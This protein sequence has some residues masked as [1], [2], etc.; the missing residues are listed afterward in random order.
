M[1]SDPQKTVFISYRRS[2]SRYLARLIFKSLHDA[3]YDV[4]L[5]VNTIDSGAFDEMILRQI[6]ARAH[7]VLVL[8]PGALERCQN[9][10][11]WLQ[12]EIEEA[13]RLTRNVIPIIEEGFN[14]DKEINFLPASIRDAFR[15]YNGVGLYHEYFDAAMEKLTTRFLKDPVIQVRLAQPPPAEQH[16]VR[17]QIEQVASSPAPTMDE[18]NAEGYFNRGVAY[19]DNRDK[20][21]YYYSEAIR[22]N[23]AY[24]AAYNNRGFSYKAKGDYDNAIAD[25]TEA[26]RL[27]PQLV[28][29]YNNRGSAYKAK[30][31]YDNAIA[32]YTEAIRLNPQYLHA[33]FNRAGTYEQK[34]DYAAAIADYQT[35]LDLGGG[36][37]DGDQAQVEA[38]IAELKE[39]LNS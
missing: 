15:R 36:K 6:A 3:G 26:L 25:Y 13:M 20:Q 32:D 8:S 7:F 11:D 2:A 35:Y 14:F 38:W 27:S 5:D 12:R 23:P 37:R 33:Y 22:L 1:T 30:G 17:Q 39:K 24:V 21:I 28:G 9:E 4:F 16:E 19:N 31:D 34:N 10:G 18:L 29:S